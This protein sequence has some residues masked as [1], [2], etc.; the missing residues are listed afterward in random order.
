MAVIAAV[1]KC[2]FIFSSDSFFES[3]CLLD[4]RKLMYGI[5]SESTRGIEPSIYC[6]LKFKNQTHEKAM[7]FIQKGLKVDQ[8]NAM[9]ASEHYMQSAALLSQALEIGHDDV[10]KM[11]AMQRQLD[12]I[13]DHIRYL[14]RENSQ[15]SSF[16]DSQNTVSIPQRFEADASILAE[17]SSSA[18]RACNFFDVMQPEK[19]PLNLRHAV[20]ELRPHFEALVSHFGFQEASFRNQLEHVVMLLHNCGSHGAD[21]PHMLLS[22]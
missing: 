21:T 20:V 13:E 10:Q 4:S 9:Q 1:L 5:R 19:L 17:T 18:M 3:R 12:I 22:S 2:S 11:D 7:D 6:T 15:R 16:T 14:T 8:V